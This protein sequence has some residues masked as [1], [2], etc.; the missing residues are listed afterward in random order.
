[1][2]RVQVQVEIV[3]ACRQGAARSQAFKQQDHFRVHRAPFAPSLHR[4]NNVCN[5]AFY[6]G[7]I[8][9]AAVVGMM[10]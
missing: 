4:L 8:Q 6:W 1:M 10:Q 5:S 2:C 9:G 3:L 7:G